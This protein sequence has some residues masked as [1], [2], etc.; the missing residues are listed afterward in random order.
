M[1]S[2]NSRRTRTRKNLR[3]E[4]KHDDKLIAPLPF[5]IEKPSDARPDSCT[6]YTQ[7][8]H[9]AKDNSKS[10][11]NFKKNIPESRI[12][13]SYWANNIRTYYRHGID[14]DAEY[15]AAVN[16]VTPEDVKAILQAVL[17]ANNLIEV[18]SAP[19]E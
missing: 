5:A 17:A 13:N 12:S 10:G 16:S 14:Y 18:T 1:T 3:P 6:Y 8:K 15:E 2:S 11:E 4:L 7:S 9:D 19:K